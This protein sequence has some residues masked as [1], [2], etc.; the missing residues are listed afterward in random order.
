METVKSLTARMG[1]TPVVT[2]PLQISQH[3]EAMAHLNIAIAAGQNGGT[4]A[5]VLYHQG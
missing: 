4:N 1:L 3:L 5:A 2:G